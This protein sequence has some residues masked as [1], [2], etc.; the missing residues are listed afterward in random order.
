MQNIHCELLI[1][2]LIFDFGLSD[3][4]MSNNLVIS[5][6]QWKYIEDKC[7]D[8]FALIF[9]YVILHLKDGWLKCHSCH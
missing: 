8:L 4:C 6:L 5:D 9:A 1:C 2:Y 3:T 7:L